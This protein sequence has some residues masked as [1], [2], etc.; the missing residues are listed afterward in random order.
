MTFLAVPGLG[1]ELLEGAAAEAA[2]LPPWPLGGAASAAAAGRIDTPKSDRAASSMNERRE[3]SSNE[4][5]KSD[6]LVNL[7]YRWGHSASQATA[8]MVWRPNESRHCTN[9]NSRVL[10]SAQI[11]LP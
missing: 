9:K 1:P 7:G 6:M 8:E 5:I 10:T 4:R 3:G 2:F 11:T